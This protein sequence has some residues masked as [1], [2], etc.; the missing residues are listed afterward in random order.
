MIGQPRRLL[1][2]TTV[3]A[4]AVTIHAATLKFDAPAGWVSKPPASTMRIVEYTLPKVAPDTED[5]ALAVFFFGGQGGSVQANLDRW[6]GQMTQPDGRAS[7]DVAKTT[8]FQTTSGLKVSLIDLTGTYV[9]EMSP[10][11]ADHFNKPGFRLR[12]AVIETP[13]G[14]YYVKLTGPAATV[15]KWDKE[16]LAFVKSGKS[17]GEPGNRGTGE[18]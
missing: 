6:I 16:F 18:R 15:A 10:G 12:A 1:I 8:T 13:D 14:S 17:T 2:A 9:A 7:K 5:A 4:C 3:I 11:S